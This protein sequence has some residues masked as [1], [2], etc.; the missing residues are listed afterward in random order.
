MANF[1]KSRNHQDNYYL[2]KNNPPFYIHRTEVSDLKHCLE[3]AADQ[4]TGYGKWTTDHRT[5]ST[6][7]A[8]SGGVLIDNGVGRRVRLSYD[9]ARDIVRQ[10]E[11]RV[12]KEAVL[13]QKLREMSR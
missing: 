7:E 8:D 13:E 1:D 2:Q 5:P 11:D 3:S 10:I 9:E 4:R 6:V 12:V